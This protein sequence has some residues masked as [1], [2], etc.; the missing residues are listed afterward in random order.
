MNFKEASK[1]RIPFGK[2][3]GKTIDQVASSDDGLRYLDWLIGEGKLYGDLKD[4]LETYMSD[5]VI[6]K[7]IE[8]IVGG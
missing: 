5:E 2:F 3:K 8:R 1:Y 6:Q 4:A 7:E